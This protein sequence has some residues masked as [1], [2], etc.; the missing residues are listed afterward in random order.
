MRFFTTFGL[1]LILMSLVWA[2]EEN[3]LSEQLEPLR[4]FVGKTWRGVVAGSD[5]AKQ[6][7]DVSKWERALNG[8]AVR[9]LHSVNDGA[10]GGETIVFWD[11]EKEKLVY[12][13]FTTAGF[14]TQG[15][16]ALEGK[17][18]TAHEYV[19]G[20]QDGIT[21]VKSSGEILPDGSL[22]TFS[23]FL[24]NGEWVQGRETIYREDPDAE[25]IFR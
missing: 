2:Q 19:T 1:T 24:K 11:R 7:V 8:R 18:F 13:Y 4:P 6:T 20:N 12:Y 22:K 21:E 3:S 14:M 17:I 9:I 25:V 5:S 16:F 23:T 15:T 10:Y